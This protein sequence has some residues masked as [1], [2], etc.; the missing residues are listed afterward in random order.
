MTNSIKLFGQQTKN[1]KQ[2]QQYI[3]TIFSVEGRDVVE[4][5][6]I[7]KVYSYEEETLLT[8]AQQ[9]QAYVADLFVLTDEIYAAEVVDED[10]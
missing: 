9:K 1:V 7:S 2:G 6:P 10:K 4:L 5:K 3:A 8:D